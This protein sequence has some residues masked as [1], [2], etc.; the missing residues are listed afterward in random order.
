MR[1]NK[2][3]AR[4]RQS[5]RSQYPDGERIK[6]KMVEVVDSS[7]IKGIR[8]V[9]M[10]LSMSLILNL[11]VNII[12]GLVEL[13]KP[14]PILPANFRVT[15]ITIIAIKRGISNLVMVVWVTCRESVP[16]VLPLGK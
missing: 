5:K 13:S 4:N 10:L 3:K 8:G 2:A 12:F 11:L 7:L 9:P 15:C 14:H 1:K 16:Q 6:E